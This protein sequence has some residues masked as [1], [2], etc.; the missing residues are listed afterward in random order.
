VVDCRHAVIL[1]MLAVKGGCSGGLQACSYS[2]HVG[3]DK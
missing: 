3:V 1:P 2:A